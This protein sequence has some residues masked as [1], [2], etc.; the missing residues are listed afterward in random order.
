MG[1][2]AREIEQQIKETRQRMDDSL[3]RLEGRATSNAKRYGVIAGALAGAAVL[4]VAAFI[5]YRRAH[6]LT[7]RERLSDLSLH[8]LSVLVDRL[9]E[10]APSVT[11]RVNER[12]VEEPSAV[13]SILRRAA[14]ALVGTAG[15][16]LFQRL[17]SPPE[18]GRYPAPQAE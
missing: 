3:N 5:V 8:E 13:E 9:K 2:S 18:E 1:A 6:R 15:S 7:L 10:A 14:P 12:T 17:A 16:A 11:L 4:A